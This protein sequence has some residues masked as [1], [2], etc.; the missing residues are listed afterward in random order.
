MF[1]NFKVRWQLFNFPV[2]MI[3]T[4]T[5]IT[6]ITVS[7]VAGNSAELREN[8]TMCLVIN[9]F[10]LLPFIILSVINIFLLGITTCT[11]KEDGVEIGGN[12]VKYNDIV[13]VY[14]EPPRKFSLKAVATITTSHGNSVSIVHAPLFILPLLKKVN[15]NIRIK[16]DII[17]FT[18]YIGF[19]VG[20]LIYIAVMVVSGNNI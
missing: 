7:I 14:Y 12:L 11:L 5:L 16:L 20:G 8:L 1:K 19:T 13:E 2:Y 4:E 3:L 18:I 9:L 10:F 17:S 15:K 6:S